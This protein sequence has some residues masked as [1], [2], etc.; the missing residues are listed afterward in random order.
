MVVA[1]VAIAAQAT[2]VLV[3]ENIEINDICFTA[4]M[5]KAR[6]NEMIQLI[7][8]YFITI[9][10]ELT[11]ISTLQTNAG[12]GYNCELFPFGAIK[13]YQTTPENRRP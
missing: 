3:T 1:E 7:A 12:I 4:C 8:K 13:S 6:N 11:I 10:H 2:T 5:M 9:L